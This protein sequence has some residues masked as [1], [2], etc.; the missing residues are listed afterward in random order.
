MNDY[1]IIKIEKQIIAGNFSF[2][3][4]EKSEI[5][6][7]FKNKFYLFSTLIYKL[8]QNPNYSSENWKS[9]TEFL[10]SFNIKLVN[11]WYEKTII[12]NLW[13]SFLKEKTSGLKALKELV[14]YATIHHKKDVLLIVKNNMVSLFSYRRNLNTESQLFE[15]INYFTPELFLTTNHFIEHVYR[16]GAK[17]PNF[18]EVAIQLTSHAE[19][20]LLNSLVDKI[21]NLLLFRKVNSNN[22]RILFKA[23][24]EDWIVEKLKNKNKSEIIEKIVAFFEKAEFKDIDFNDFNV[25]RQLIYLDKYFNPTSTHAFV[26]KIQEIYLLKLYRRR[27]G[28]KLSNKKKIISFLSSIPGANPKKALYQLIK[29]N[30]SKDIDFLIKKFPELAKLAILA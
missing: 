7:L 4:K 30:K 14:K 26:D 1:L 12:Y 20:K 28:H 2:T 11:V 8:L 25:L 22:R 3:E 24:N 23:L 13:S 16:I 21:E 10:Y 19:E 29:I 9:L 15:I 6:N 27:V 18:F 5:K 17:Q